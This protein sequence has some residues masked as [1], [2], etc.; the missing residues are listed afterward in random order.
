MS[1]SR[2]LSSATPV[3]RK[4]S[5]DFSLIGLVYSSMMMF[6]GLAAVNTQ[7]NLLFGVFGLMVGVLLVAMVLSRA[8]LRRLRVDRVLPEHAIVGQKTTLTYR[9]R[10]AKRFWPSFSVSLGE[11]DGC[12]AFAKQPYTYMMHAAAGTTA[13]V[14]T[15]VQPQR[16][17]VYTLDRHQLSTSFPF[18]FIKRAL[19]RTQK[20]TLVV[21][22]AIGQVDG[23]LLTLCRSAENTGAMMRPRRG[24]LDEIYG[25]KEYRQG[26]NP[27]WIYWKR[28][29]RTGTL[30]SKE[31]TQVAPPRLVLLVDSFCAGPSL[32]AHAA[33]ERAI[34]MAASLAHYA[35]EQNMSVGLYA[36][37]G[38]EWSLLAPSRGKRHRRDIL[39]GLA[40]LPLNTDQPLE[41]ALRGDTELMR[42]GATVILFTPRNVEVGLV[43]RARSS[44][45]V[46]NADS[47]Q[48]QRWFHFPPDLDFAHAMPSDQQ[49]QPATDN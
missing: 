15:E 41:Q 40:R 21:Y 27:R 49:P 32:A 19:I 36:W 46:I 45:L 43:E 26:D 42:S 20:D 34:A 5:L 7:A 39:T 10:N 4:P 31:M 6:M 24:G 14:P 18:G 44:F 9:F 22:P 38:K 13:I 48:A 47:Q 23:R 29:A 12:D 3:R 2:K 8:V 28:S 30:V 11:L 1:K 16:R 25:L 33:V 17:G 37:S 35:L